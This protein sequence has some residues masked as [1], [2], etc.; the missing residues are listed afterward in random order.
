MTDSDDDLPDNVI[1][2]GH[3][4]PWAIA[5]GLGRYYQA[6]LSE[7]LPERISALFQLFELESADEIPNEDKLPQED[8]PQIEKV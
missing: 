2:F 5:E 4:I 1:P 8:K 6:L 7:E 3:V